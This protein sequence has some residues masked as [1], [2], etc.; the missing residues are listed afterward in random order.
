M[1]LVSI[2]ASRLSTTSCAHLVWI[3]NFPPCASHQTSL[4]SC[5]HWASISILSTECSAHLLVTHWVSHLLRILP[6]SSQFLLF[7]P[8]CPHLGAFTWLQYL[9]FPPLVPLTYFVHSFAW[10]QDFTS[11]LSTTFCI[12]LSLVSVSKLPPLVSQQ[13]LALIWFQ[14]LPSPS[15]PLIKLNF[16]HSL[17]F[18]IYTSP[19]C[20]HNNF[21]HASCFKFP[22]PPEQLPAFIWFY[23][24]GST[25][26]S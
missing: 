9:N 24:S 19:R 20:P 14:Y 3:S 7:T 26:A 21:L 18:N 4:T 2:S 16:L 22:V 5:I 8:L 1:H 6:S 11:G 10:S 13:L 23:I 25:V 12:H 17:G 15:V